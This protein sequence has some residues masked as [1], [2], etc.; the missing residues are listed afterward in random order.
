MYIGGYM[1]L[2]VFSY[3]AWLLWQ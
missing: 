2:I 1:K 3:S